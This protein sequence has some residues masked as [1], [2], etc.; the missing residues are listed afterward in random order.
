[1]DHS[2]IVTYGE[3]VLRSRAEEVAEF[4]SDVR[5]LIQRMYRV[6]EESRGLG[7]AAPQIGVAKRVFVYDVGEGKHA[8]VNPR[9]LKASGEE[10]G[11]EGCL[12]IPG[13]QG[14]VPRSERVVVS[15][16]DENGNKVKIKAQ[17]LLARVFQH[18]MDHL[19][20]T[21]FIDRADPDTLETVSVNDEDEYAQE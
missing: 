21:M 6:M 12:S 4:N 13:L 9:M 8:L 16:I 3:S 20:G 1:M 7:L 11:I 19:D 15:G 18:E 2:E 14:E 5:E 10:I 17:G